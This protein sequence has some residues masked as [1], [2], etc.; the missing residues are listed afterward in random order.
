[1]FNARSSVTIFTLFRIPVALHPSWLILMGLMTYVWTQSLIEETGVSLAI[2]FVAAFLGVLTAFSSLVAHEYGHALA[3]RYYGIA[4]RRITLF[5]FGGVAE[6][7]AEPKRPIE[8]FVIAIA[9]PAVSVALALTF[10]LGYLAAQALPIP[11]YVDQIL[12]SLF[13]VNLILAIFNMLPG[14]PMDGG[15]VLR[16]AIWAFTGN[17]LTA[18]RRAA[19]GGQVVGILLMGLG[20]FQLFTGDWSGL[21]LALT[22]YFINWL[23]KGSYQ[24]SQVKSALD[25]IRVRDLMRPVQIV[26]PASMPLDRVVREFFVLCGGDRLAVVE[27]D[28]LKG[29]LSAD[30]VALVPKDQWPRLTALSAARRWNP[31]HI[32]EVNEPIM[33]VWAKLRG[34][35]GELAAFDNSTLVGFLHPRD[36]SAYL[37]RFLDQTKL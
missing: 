4:T 34:Q 33:S 20:L 6:L 5:L 12:L 3:A 15:R 36:V 30:D 11:P 18:T 16:A 28:E 26:V 24:Q 37:N 1:M 17:Y 19:Q 9:G 8:E 21:M 27:G 23:A 35:R 22:G 31:R 13:A 14:F 25:T 7:L 2:G 29:C 10:G 32:V